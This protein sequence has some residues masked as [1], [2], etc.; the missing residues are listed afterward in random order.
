MLPDINLLSATKKMSQDQRQLEV[1][2]EDTGAAL[3]AH[4]VDH[5]AGG[6]TVGPTVTR[7]ELELGPGVKVAR[8]TQPVQ[9]HRLRHGVARRAD[10]GAHPGQVGHRRRGA[11]PDAA[12]WWRCGDIL[13]SPEAE[14]AATHPLE[15]AM[16]RDIAGRAVMANLAEMPHILISGATGSGK[17]SCINSIITSILMRAT[18]DQVRLILIDPK[19]VE[20]GQYNGLPHLLT[21]VVVDPKKAA[22]ALQLGGQG[23]G[24]PLRPAGRERHARHHRLQPAWRRASWADRPSVG[25]AAHAEVAATRSGEDHA[26]VDAEDE[27]DDEPDARS[28]CPSS[29]SWWTS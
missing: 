10:P 18:P 8:V 9:G 22:N 4:G 6:K 29:S 2:G 23:D 24:A 26:A 25:P 11:Q 28:A 20:L 19:R 27:L 12:S 16:G 13:A 7:F 17:S 21:P 1:A 15:V 14:P 3:D 5:D